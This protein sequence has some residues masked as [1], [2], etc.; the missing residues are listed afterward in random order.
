MGKENFCL[1]VSVD[2]SHLGQ[3]M[4]KNRALFTKL[5]WSKMTEIEFEINESSSSTL[6]F[7]IREHAC[8]KIFLMIFQPA[9]P[10][11][12]AGRIPLQL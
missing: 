1:F 9:Q 12:A 5:S 7:L 4:D 11:L 6:I 8:N 3:W 10:F 2:P